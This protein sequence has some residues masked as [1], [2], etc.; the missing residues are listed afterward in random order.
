MEAAT[1]FNNHTTLR[2]VMQAASNGMSLDDI[3]NVS[4]ASSQIR[5]ALASIEE[6]ILPA[7]ALPSIERYVLHLPT[8][9]WLRI[10]TGRSHGRSAGVIT[11]HAG[12][13]ARSQSQEWWV[14]CPFRIHDI[15]DVARGDNRGAE[16]PDGAIGIEE[17]KT[18][19]GLLKR[20][21]EKIGDAGGGITQLL[22]Y[23]SPDRKKMV[24]SLLQLRQIV[25]GEPTHVSKY[26]TA[27]ACDIRRLTSLGIEGDGAATDATFHGDGGPFL[28]DGMT[29]DID[30]TFWDT[31]RVTDMTNLA[32]RLQAR[33]KGI[34]RWNTAR[35]RSMSGMFA[36]SNFNQDIGGWDVRQVKSMSGMFAR[37]PFNRALGMWD[38]R[39]VESMSGMFQFSEF[40]QPLR[41]D[42][43][44]VTDMSWMFH[45]L[46]AFNQPIGL[47]TSK[48]TSMRGM[49]GSCAAFNQPLEFDTSNVTDMCDTFNGCAAFNQPIGFDTSK[50]TSMR[51]TFG[52][53]AAFNQPLVLDTSNVA[54]MAATFGRC[55]TFNQPL[56]LDTS[57]V[58]SMRR[59]F[60]ECAAFNQPLRLHSTSKVTD[61]SQMFSGCAAFNQ[62]LELDTR[63][64]TDT[65]QMFGGCAAF[66]QPLGFDTSKVTA[67]YQMFQGA[68]A[69]DQ[70]I[71]TWAVGNVIDDRLMFG[72]CPIPESHMP[73]TGLTVIGPN[74]ANLKDELVLIAR[75]LF[76]INARTSGTAG[77]KMKVVCINHESDTTTVTM[78]KAKMDYLYVSYYAEG[79]TEPDT[80]ENQKRVQNR[81]IG[82]ICSL[83]GRVMFNWVAPLSNTV[84]SS[85]PA[86]CAV[87]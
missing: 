23:E 70:K 61:M 34:E 84:D 78:N 55:T 86:S 24:T 54:D 36:G 59:M 5:A 1:V 64:V 57:K 72:G 52:S 44:K 40:N 79:E 38:V 13:L 74:A 65:T 11:A 58:T 26:G 63:E 83:H 82:Y 22:D 45:G 73:H 18:A 27:A 46:A 48:V 50:V 31:S 39:R 16:W 56:V 60:E 62:P 35:V 25:K 53:C 29:G 12:D 21:R 47:D 15:H 68:A 75:R 4:G 43:S 85:C 14:V 19:R 67:M 42:T 3:T 10:M 7:S 32:R 17:T 2:V 33:L 37:S 9:E 30:V 81:I 28:F 71:S 51:G 80:A 49:F 69:F 8:W 41:L 77:T 6:A 20:C 66:N 87:S 76:P